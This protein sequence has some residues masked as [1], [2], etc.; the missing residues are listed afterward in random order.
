[1]FCLVAYRGTRELCFYC[2]YTLIHNFAMLLIILTFYL[3]TFPTYFFW[4]AF[5]IFC[6]TVIVQVAKAADARKRKENLENERRK[7][8]ETL[9]DKLN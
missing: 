6:L 4:L 3:E 7:M 2:R 5:M 8:K 9:F 1:M